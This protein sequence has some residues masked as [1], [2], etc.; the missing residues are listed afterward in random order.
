VSVAPVFLQLGRKT[1]E[2]R[3]V[4]VR[5]GDYAE[6]ALPVT[7]PHA[8]DQAAR[9]MG[10]GVAFCHH[11][12]PLHN[13]IPEWN[14]LVAEG[15]W[16]RAHERLAA[17]NNFPEFTGRLCPA[18]CE[19]A[20]V[21]ELGD[22]AVTIKEIEA[23]V[24]DEA[25]REGW[26]VPR[27]PS[28]RSGRVVAVI[29]SGPAGLAAAQQLNAQGHTVTVYERADRLGGLMRYGIPD[30]KMDKSLIDRR[31]GV[32]AAEG[33]VFETGCEVGA[34]LSV[35]ELSGGV[36]AVVLALGAEQARDLDVPGRSLAG[37]EPAMS[38]LVQQNRRVAGDA[39]THPVIS[40]AGRHVVIIGGG[41]TA[42][43]CLGNAHRERAAS[44]TELSIYPE[45]PAA[46]TGTEDWPNVPFVLSMTPAHQEGGER[47]W[48][49]LV[50]AFGGSGALASVDVVRVDVKGS[51]PS[52]TVRTRPG[53][54]TTI[55]CDLALLAIGFGGVRDQPVLSVLGVEV[56]AQGTLAAD[57]HERDD[58]PIVVAAGDA[59]TGAALVVTAIADGRRAA[60]LVDRRL[61]AR[62]DASSDDVP[63]D[64]AAWDALQ[65]G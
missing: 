54:E 10:C 53:S 39:S 59:V 55:R 50:T 4:E 56:L 12:C 28:G 26:V 1:M 3:P 5:V 63:S 57:G 48:S 21:L 14:E 37:V 40:A 30:Y 7:A 43:D 38:Y 6:V 60:A 47:T 15:D 29:G 33:I 65:L 18:P 17:T 32:L 23:A 62:A 31:V 41:D 42:T 25:F 35:L 27:A 9:C 64:R 46:R 24:A 51:G 11:H 19:S 8:K 36:D 34:D 13:L 16:R 44:V 45:P 49:V 58:G 52:R 20:C 2:Q 22:E 61:R